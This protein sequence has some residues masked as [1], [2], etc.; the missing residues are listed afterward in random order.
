MPQGSLPC[1]MKCQGA[2][3]QI[4]AWRP[5]CVC[6]HTLDRAGGT[7]GPAEDGAQEGC[8]ARYPASSL[9][10][11]SLLVCENTKGHPVTRTWLSLRVQAQQPLCFSALEFSGSSAHLRTSQLTL[12]STALHPVITFPN[13][14]NLKGN[15]SLLPIKGLS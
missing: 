8:P 15:P 9:T 12:K 3:W 13:M 5:L 11:Q 6:F 14:I 1:P 2:A 7:Q 10:S 4:T